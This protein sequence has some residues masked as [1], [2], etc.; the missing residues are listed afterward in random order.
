[1]N[2]DTIRQ[3][4]DAIDAATAA[5]R[6][7]LDEAA[8]TPPAGTP[9]ADSDELIV[10]LAE[11]GAIALAPGVPF[12]AGGGFAITVPDTT[13]AGLGGN[14]VEA[15]TAPAIRVVPGV[16]GAAI[17]CLAG[18]TGSD[19][20]VIQIGR[21]DTE[22]ATIEAAPLGVT[23][24]A[25]TST[26]HRG[27]RAIEC[28]GRDVA[29]L[30]CEVHD[31]FDPGG[32]DSQAIWIGNCPGPVRVAGGY[33]E[34]ASENLMIGGDSMKIPGCRPT[35]IAIVGAT[36]EKPI[37]WKAEGGPSVKNLI[38]CKDGH[39]VTIEDCDLVRCWKSGQDGYAFMFTPAN[40]GSVRNAVVRNCRV[41][42]VG[43]IV[44]VTGTD[45]AGINPERTQV[46]IYGGEYRTNKAAMGGS[47]RFLLA[48]RGPESLIVRD[49]Y[50]AH[51]GNAFADL[52]DDDAPIDVLEIRGCTWNY[53]SY[54]IRIGGASHGDNAYGLI[55][56]ITITGNTI[57]GA[58][59]AFR[60]RYPD[61]A[62]LASM[63]R[64]REVHVDR[65]AKEYA[66]SVRDELARVLAWEREYRL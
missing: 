8:P 33:F 17:E 65:T 63:S 38:E 56:S 25:V 13:I 27:K 32:R 26:G 57:T 60:E 14:T 37:A 31:C 43:G 1:M 28:N 35:D 44:N 48:Q 5:I 20:G 18:R 4:C 40:G 23:I 42:E 54:G 34:G 61:N 51:E 62:Y 6:A 29:I 64:D 9:V 2:P 55:G 47:G 45:A 21:N 15:S 22:Q 46:A 30:D 36:F 11:G 3:H 52:A 12:V 7:D 41:R 58:H 10:A 39:N 49:A 59:S 66:R 19:G 50:I 53:G 24:R 16:P